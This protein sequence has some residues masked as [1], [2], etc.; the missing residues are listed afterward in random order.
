M[1]MREKVLDAA[2]KCVCGDRD[3]EY[4]APEDTFICIADMWTAYLIKRGWENIAIMPADVAWMM[5]LFKA[6][7]AAASPAHLDNAIDCAGYAACAAEC[8]PDAP[9]KPEE[10]KS[11]PAAWVE[12]HGS[13]CTAC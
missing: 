1:T 2:K 3:I 4:G 6:A 11:G 9:E 12:G 7:R 10:D 8:L 5:V 13:G